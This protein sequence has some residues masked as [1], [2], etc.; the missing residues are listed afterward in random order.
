[1]NFGRKKKLSSQQAWTFT[2]A[3]AAWDQ[4]FASKPPAWHCLSGK[5]IFVVRLQIRVLILIRGV[6]TARPLWK[7]SPGAAYMSCWNAEEW[8]LSW[9]CSLVLISANWQLKR[10]CNLIFFRAGENAWGWDYVCV[11]TRRRAFTCLCVC[12]VR[13]CKFYSLHMMSLRTFF[14]L[15]VCTNNHDYY[16]HKQLNLAFT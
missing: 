14:R 3:R 8:P 16:L 6:E 13:A 12:C 4:D 15:A 10:N 9:M 5:L 1:M 11:H 2:R 7:G